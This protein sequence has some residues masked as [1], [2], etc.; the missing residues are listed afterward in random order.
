MFKN[1]NGSV[2]EIDYPRIIDSGNAVG[3]GRWVYA[4]QVCDAFLTV[5]RNNT[6]LLLMT[7]KPRQR[8]Y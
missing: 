1:T 4:S 8:Y 6:V 5:A 3:F 7:E 2:G